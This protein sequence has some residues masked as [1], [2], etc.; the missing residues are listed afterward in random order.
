MAE[1]IKEA[2]NQFPLGTLIVFIGV[3]LVAA[4]AAMVMIS[5]SARTFEKPSA[6]MAPINGV[7]YSMNETEAFRIAALGCRNV[8][9]TGVALCDADNGHW[10]FEMDL[11]MDNCTPQ[12]VVDF[13]QDTTDIVC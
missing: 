2:K 9:A 8:S 7:V 11:E 5:M 13:I 10:V 12:C 3:I 1:E 6:C 4:V